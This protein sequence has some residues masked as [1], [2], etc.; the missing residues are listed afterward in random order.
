M[1]K[2]LRFAWAYYDTDICFSMRDD[3]QEKIGSKLNKLKYG[4]EARGARLEGPT[5][6]GYGRSNKGEDGHVTRSSSRNWVGM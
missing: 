1:S 2:S 6:Q 5:K 4:P 3:G